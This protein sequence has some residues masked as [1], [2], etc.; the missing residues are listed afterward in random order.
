MADPRTS[1]TP[2][3]GTLAVLEYLWG[4]TCDARL[5][6]FTIDV[7]LRG[8]YFGFI[9]KQALAGEDD[10]KILT[11]EELA[12]TKPGPLITELRK[13]RQQLLEMFLSRAVDN[14]QHYLV[15]VIRVALQKEPRILSERKQEL[16]LGKILQF[17][18]IEALTR[19]IIE[20]KLSSLAYE[21]FGALEKWCGEKTIPLVVPDGSRPKVIELIALRNIIVHARGRVDD[22]YKAA[23]P[24]SV[25]ELGQKREIEVDDLFDAIGLL[26][27]IVIATD[28]AITQ[29]FGLQL[30]DIQDELARRTAAR[31]G[32]T[33]QNIANVGS[34]D[35]NNHEE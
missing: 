5:L 3:S 34:A 28:G 6:H 30:H 10:Y 33:S 9:A 12:K 35:E 20:T 8:D 29:K 11:P 26:N 21:G 7:V 31:H 19:N 23:V 14:F 17:E 2:S 22:R 4:S 25:L 13:S 32:Q 18:S 24:S 15:D 16:T 27:S 1:T